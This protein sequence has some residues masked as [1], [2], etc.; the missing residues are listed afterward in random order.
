LVGEVN[1]RGTNATRAREL[2]G[3][4]LAPETVEPV[5]HEIVDFLSSRLD[6]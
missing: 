2:T 5:V 3:A 6:G 1:L 4:A